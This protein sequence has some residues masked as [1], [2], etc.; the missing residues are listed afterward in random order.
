MFL[1]FTYSLTV[2]P[3]TRVDFS[4]DP[5]RKHLRRQWQLFAAPRIS[6]RPDVVRGWH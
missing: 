1:V 6:G 5:R 3:A 4:P 2:Q